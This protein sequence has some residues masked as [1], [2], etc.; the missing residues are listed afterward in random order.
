MIAFQS[1]MHC[2]IS[3]DGSDRTH[4]N[5]G[6]AAHTFFEADKDIAGVFVFANASRNT[7]N[8]AC[9]IF[10]IPALDCDR[11]NSKS[12][13]LVDRLNVNSWTMNRMRR[14]TSQFA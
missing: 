1:L 11:L 10:A 12:P 7:G 9:R 3:C 5:A 4:H 8:G 13:L 2:I 14:S 6:P